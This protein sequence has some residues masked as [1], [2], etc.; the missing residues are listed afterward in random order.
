MSAFKRDTAS[1]MK[2]F[3]SSR[4][5]TADVLPLKASRSEYE[6]GHTLPPLEYTVQRPS[7]QNGHSLLLF[8]PEPGPKLLAPHT[9]HA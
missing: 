6:L 1:Y 8:K 9:M 4:A 5:G 7:L 2:A 3:V